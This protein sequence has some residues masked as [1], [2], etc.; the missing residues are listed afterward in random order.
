MTSTGSGPPVEQCS[1]TGAGSYGGTTSRRAIEADITSSLPTAPRI[2]AGD[3]RLVPALVSLPGGAGLSLGWHDTERDTDCTFA[4]ASDGKLRCLPTG[5]QATLFHT[6]DACKS[7]GVV[8]VLDKV[9]CT[10]PPRFAR[11]ATSACAPTSRLFELGAQKR[12]LTVASIETAPGHCPTQAVTNALDATEVDPA[13]FVEG[14]AV[15]E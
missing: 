1:S 14:V 15:T 9:P 6:D 12:D 4:R 7:P 11:V 10:G 5:A 2:N 8:A 3:G 13:G